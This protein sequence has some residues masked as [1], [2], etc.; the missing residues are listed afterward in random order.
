MTKDEIWSISIQRARRFFREQAD[1]REENP[2]EFTFGTCRIRL[3]EPEPGK[4]GSWTIR[5]TRLQMEGGDADTAVIYHRYFTQF[6][7]AGG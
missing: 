7:S 4:V 1:V 5:R 2:D 6:L 3:T